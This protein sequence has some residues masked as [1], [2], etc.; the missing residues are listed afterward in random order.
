MVLVC[1]TNLNT[2]AKKPICLKNHFNQQ[3]KNVFKSFQKCEPK[4]P[5]FLIIKTFLTNSFEQNL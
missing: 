5:N 4:K 3:K 1:L 2:L